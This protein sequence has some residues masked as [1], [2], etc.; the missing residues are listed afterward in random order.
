[1]RRKGEKHECEK[2]IDKCKTKLF[3]SISSSP[4]LLISFSLFH[5]INSSRN[6]FRK[7]FINELMIGSAGFDAG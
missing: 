6:S 5:L 3:H 1:M 4:F 7:S 2:V